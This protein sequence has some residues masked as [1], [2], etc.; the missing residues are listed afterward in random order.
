MYT[1]IRSTSLTLQALL[2]AQF[3]S[4]AIISPFFGG[5]MD[6]TLNNPEEMAT[7]GIEGVSLWLYRV[8]RDEERLN[9]PPERLGPDRLRPPPLPVRLHY[10]ITPIVN[11]NAQTLAFSPEREHLLLGKVLQI[12]YDVPLL[13]GTV[14]QDDLAGT[15][16]E[17]GVRL[18]TLTLEEITRV[19]EG[20]NRPYQLSVS[21]E[22]AVVPIASERQPLDQT[23]VQIALP[24]YGVITAITE[25]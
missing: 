23:P 4:D 9:A 15:S 8:V 22:V 2:R 1:L 20:L 24:E 13:R 17:L 6:V 21:Y 12:L 18:E 11:I 14:L 25:A 7:N 16:I 3:L 5:V 10:L 19:W